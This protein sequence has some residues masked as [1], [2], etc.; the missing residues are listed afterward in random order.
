MIVNALVWGGVWGVAGAIVQT[1]LG[2]LFLRYFSAP[3]PNGLQVNW[4][5][6]IPSYLASWAVTGAV[7]GAG[8]S[9]LL[10]KHAYGQSV[11]QLSVRRCA[12]WG[13]GAGVALPVLMQLL[14]LPSPLGVIILIPFSG[15]LGASLAALQVRV[16]RQALPKVEQ[17]VLVGD[18]AT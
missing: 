1:G 11:D 15:A 3:L 9:A 7:V 2:F 14:G 10:I 12:A 17:P 8:F 13:A 4:G 6:L 5:S 16:A 18:G